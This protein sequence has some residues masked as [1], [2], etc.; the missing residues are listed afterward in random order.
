MLT[1]IIIALGKKAKKIRDRAAMPG[2]AQGQ[3]KHAY[4]KIHPDHAAMQTSASAAKGTGKNKGNS[5]PLLGAFN[6]PQVQHVAG[7]HVNVNNNSEGAA[8]REAISKNA[9][10][11]HAAA[12]VHKSTSAD[13][14]DHEYFQ[15]FYTPRGKVQV[16]AAI[17]R[18]DE[19][20]ASRDALIEQLQ[21]ELAQVRAEQKAHTQE[22]Q[23]QTRARKGES[24]GVGKGSESAWGYAQG[25]GKGTGDGKGKG[26]GK[27][28]QDGILAV[29]Q[30]L[31][32]KS[33]KSSIATKFEIFDLMKQ[34]HRLF[35]HEFVI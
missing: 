28:N 6:R 12:C 29:P 15:T 18:R 31:D 30:Q 3:G 22:V 26:K 24:K 14:A 35:F 8:V 23:T 2:A 16:N 33:F 20:I 13:Q 11:K 1:K 21:T 10:A 19:G 7:N 34:F 9:L 32:S 17:M 25:K 4:P 27:S 5:A